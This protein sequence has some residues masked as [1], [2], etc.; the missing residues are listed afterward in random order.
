MPLCEEFSA[1]RSTGM[2]ARRVGPFDSL[3]SISPVLGQDGL[4]PERAALVLPVSL[5][6]L[7]LDVLDHLS[8]APR[9]F[10]ETE[11][12]PCGNGREEK[13]VLGGVELRACVR[14]ACPS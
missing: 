4:D 5:L 1:L 7:V 11:V 2:N 8:D 6:G 10:L 3:G 9:D 14:G 13:L 12:I